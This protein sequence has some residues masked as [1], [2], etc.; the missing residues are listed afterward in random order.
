MRDD[1]DLHKDAVLALCLHAVFPRDFLQWLL[2]VEQPVALVQVELSPEAPF[3]THCESA[4][5]LWGVDQGTVPSQG[6]QSH[7]CVLGR[8]GETV[9]VRVRGEGERK[10]STVTVLKNRAITVTWGERGRVNVR[11]RKT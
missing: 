11:M 9:N 3:R 6:L 10:Y 8:E 5:A 7:H 2:L 4:G 1:T